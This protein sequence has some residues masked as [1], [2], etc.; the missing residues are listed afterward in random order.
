MNCV[1]SII[2]PIY[3]GSSY[4]RKCLD[5][6]LI[7]KTYGLELILINDGSTDDSPNICRDYQDRYDFIQV[8]NQ[9]N[10]GPGIA[11]KRG[12]ELATGLYVSFVDADDWLDIVALRRVL[13]QLIEKDADII[14][15]GYQQVEDDGRIK[16][17]HALSDTCII[18]SDECS[19]YYARRSQV[20]NFLWDKIFRRS[21]LTDVVFPNFYYSEDAC[22]LTQLYNKANMVVRLEQIVYNYL[23]NQNGLCKSVF[24]LKK[25]DSVKA[26]IFM[27]DY[28]QKNNPHLCGYA[29]MYVCTYAAKCYCELSSFSC[30]NRN[31]IMREIRQIFR[32]H[33]LELNWDIFSSATL[34]KRIFLKTFA[35]HWML[36]MFIYRL[37]NR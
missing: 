14:E 24:S 7:G 32:K 4:L 20:T 17:K 1:L 25:L 35:L 15:F 3:N 11:R 23:I 18:G 10:S 36:G 31:S 19:R 30:E 16:S 26:G 21:L 27:Y 8:I 2:I 6:I 12:L 34:Q 22:I 9:E 37:M 33:H 29:S 5:S 28:Y 13:D